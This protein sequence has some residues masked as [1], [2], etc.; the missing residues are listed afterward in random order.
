MK[1]ILAIGGAVMKTEARGYLWDVAEDIEM[2]LVN[3][4]AL[5]HDFQMAIEGYT[6]VSLDELNVSMERIEYICGFVARHIAYNAKAP[7][8][9]FINLMR[10]QRKP[11]L[12]FTGLGC[13]Y[14]QKYLMG[15]ERLAKRAERDFN[16]LCT[17]FRSEPFHFINMCSAVIMPEVFQKA[18]QGVPEKYIHADVIDFLDMYRPRTRVAKYG[19]YYQMDV[20]EYM[21]LW[22]KEVNS[23]GS[24]ASSSVD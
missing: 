4:G 20:V 13:D 10:E 1:K 8:G 11:V 22:A 12:L 14:W 6:S 3:G 16:T 9:S 21:K 2:L 5:F 7:A 18:I 23:N 15:W 19:E 17:R 24:S